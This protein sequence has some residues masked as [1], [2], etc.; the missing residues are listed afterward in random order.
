MIRI[1]ERITAAAPSRAFLAAAGVERWP[2]I[3]PHYRLV[4]FLDQ[5][6][7]GQGV[8]E[9][10]AWRDFAGPLRY[11]VWWVSEMQ[12]DGE[13]PLIRYRH[14]DGITVGMDVRW[15]FIPAPGGTRVRIVHE[16]DGPDWPLVGGLAATTVIGPWFVSAIARRTLAGVCAE[17]ERTESGQRR[18]S[19]PDRYREETPRA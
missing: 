8:V 12:S 15:E 9:M 6:G 2:E 17:A 13:V 1:D 16:W 18:R 4:R 19:A 5:R 14:V 11:P 7:F 3:L 10:S